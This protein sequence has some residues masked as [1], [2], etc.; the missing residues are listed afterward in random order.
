MQ[1][2]QEQLQHLKQQQQHEVKQPTQPPWE[3]HSSGA[4]SNM[5]RKM[6]YGG[7][8]LGV[9]EDGITSPIKITKKQEFNQE[10]DKNIKCWPNGTV[11][12]AGSSML[13]G[14]QEKRLSV[15]GIHVKVRANPGATVMDMRDHLNAYLRK[16]PGHLILHVGGNDST[17]EETSSDDIF[18]GLLELKNFAETEV[19][20]IKVTFSC[21][22]IRSDN[23]LACIKLMFL[24]NRLIR[25]RENIISN[26]NIAQEHLGKKGL[27]LNQRGVSRLATNLK[28]Y[29][30]CL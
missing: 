5:M 19:P 7:G 25:A 9:R 12:I 4:A 21:P 18:D 26:V 22:T 15:K 24:R 20:G 1:H 29:I 23:H 27:H 11:L 14:I 3:I 10:S 6:N 30:R 28:D 8:G 13:Q 17:F 2:E 16:K